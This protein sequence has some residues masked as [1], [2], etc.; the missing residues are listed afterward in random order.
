M[1]IKLTSLLV[2]DQ[3]AALQF[4]TD[5]LGFTCKSDIPMGA[6]RWL[7]VVSPQA[8]DEIELVLEPNVNPAA[9]TYQEA[10][11]EQ[12]IPFTAF[13]VDDVNSEFTR[14]SNLGVAFLAPP[15]EMGPVK[16][17]VFNDTCG[18]LIQI[19]QNL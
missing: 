9:K 5:I 16:A 10:L 13:E 11:F 3:G 8:P 1:R 12:Q 4:Y 2:A 19:Y 6:F 14:L 17:A 15:V 7:T 18:N